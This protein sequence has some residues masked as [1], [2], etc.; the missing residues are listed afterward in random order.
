MR[1]SLFVEAQKHC[2]INLLIING[3]VMSIA[4]KCL[5]LS[6]RRL[7]VRVFSLFSTMFQQ[8]KTKARQIECNSY[9]SVFS[10]LQVWIIQE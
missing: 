9:H 6:L 2:L 5:L 10:L 4:R 7:S 8:Y 3:F 1:V